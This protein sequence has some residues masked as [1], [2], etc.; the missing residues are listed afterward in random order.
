MVRMA[1]IHL[2]FGTYERL[3]CMRDPIA[4][5]HIVNIDGSE[6][7]ST[8][9]VNLNEKKLTIKISFLSF[10]EHLLSES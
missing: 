6:I 2:C 5:Q 10:M 3:L 4:L 7:A 9:P 1:G 8:F